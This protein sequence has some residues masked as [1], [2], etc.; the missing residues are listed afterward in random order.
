MCLPVLR[1][2]TLNKRKAEKLATYK[3]RPDSGRSTFQSIKHYA[4]ELDVLGLLLICGGLALFLLPF[5]LY[6]YQAN[7]W[8]SSMIICMLVFGIITLILFGVY[9]KVLRS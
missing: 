1:I 5:S 4:I 8:R 7:Q 2:F 3:P 6:S 9:E